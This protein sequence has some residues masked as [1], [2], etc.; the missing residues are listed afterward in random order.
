M[1]GQTYSFNS[2]VFTKTLQRLLFNLLEKIQLNLALVMS[3]MSRKRWY[4]WPSFCNTLFSPYI[5]RTWCARLSLWVSI[6]SGW[7]RNVPECYREPE[8]WDCWT[9]LWN[10][11]ENTKAETDKCLF[12]RVAVAG[13]VT[14]SKKGFYYAKCTKWKQSST[15]LYKTNSRFQSISM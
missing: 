2:K 9:P 7:R 12:L 3:Q 5:L 10:K 13:S 8:G 4:L 11:R 6:S 15:I 14:F 1:E